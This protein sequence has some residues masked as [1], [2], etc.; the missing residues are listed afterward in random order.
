VRAVDED[1]VLLAAVGGVE[2]LHV[3]HGDKHVV[4]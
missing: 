4:A 2:L 1:E 3:G